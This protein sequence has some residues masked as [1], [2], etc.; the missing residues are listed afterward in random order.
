M[1]KFFVAAALALGLFIGQSAP[2]EAEL[3]YTGVQEESTFQGKKV[4]LRHY[5]DTEG[6]IE[7]KYS[8][9]VDVVDEVVGYNVYQ[10]PLLFEFA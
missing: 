3:I 7:N 4:L 1:K 9:S 2:A 6:I 8:F 5:I 10:S